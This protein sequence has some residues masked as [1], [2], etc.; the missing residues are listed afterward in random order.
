MNFFVKAAVVIA[1][2]L[3]P[4]L[5]LGATAAE[6]LAAK[7]V[8]LKKGDRII[9]FGDSLTALAGQEAPKQYVHKGYVR[10]VSRQH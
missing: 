4:A 7:K 3:L 9:F 5:P 6:D 2:V 8:T 10:I 1:V